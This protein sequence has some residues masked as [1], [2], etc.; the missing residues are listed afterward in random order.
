MDGGAPLLTRFE[1][2]ALGRLTA[3]ST[4]SRRTEYHHDAGKDHVTLLFCTK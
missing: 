4:A 2:D 3:K 1:Y